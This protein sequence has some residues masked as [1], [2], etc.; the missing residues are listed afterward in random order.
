VYGVA[1]ANEGSESLTTS[2]QGVQV[3]AGAGH[4]I[5]DGLAAGLEGRA[6][7]HNGRRGDHAFG[8]S[9]SVLGGLVDWHPDPAYPGHV[10]LGLG[11]MMT[12]GARRN[13]CPASNPP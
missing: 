1:R 10:Q 8:P 7:L 11:R 6:R 2:G 5:I 4:S 12:R 3:R 13:K 9:L